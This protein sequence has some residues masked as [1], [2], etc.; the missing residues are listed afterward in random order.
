MV[1]SRF[2]SDSTSEDSNRAEKRN[3]DN[4][5]IEE[6]TDTRASDMQDSKP[7]FDFENL[8]DT[9]FAKGPEETFGSSADRLVHESAIFQKCSYDFVERVLMGAKKALCKGGQRMIEEGAA[10]PCSMFFVLWG[11]AEV[12]CSGE[13]CSL[14]KEGDSI[15]ESQ[16]LG[17]SSKW[18]YS[19]HATSMCMVCEISRAVME[20]ALQ[21]FAEEEAHFQNILEE[22]QARKART[23]LALQG[24][25]SLRRGSEAF[26]SE[27][28]SKMDNRVYFPEQILFAEGAED[29]SL[30][31]LN[32]GIVGME[33]AGRLVRFEEVPTMHP[34][35]AVNEDL[36]LQRQNRRKSSVGLHSGSNTP[37]SHTTDSR[38]SM[39]HTT[40]HR[41]LDELDFRILG[42]ESVLGAIDAR[43]ITARAKSMCHVSILYR[44]SFRQTLSKYPHDKHL[45]QPFLNLK[46]EDTFQRIP[47]REHWPF[48]SGHL[49]D[50]FF[51]FL[52]RHIEKRILGIGDFLVLDE[53]HRNV[54]VLLTD[55]NVSLCQIDRG[56]MLLRSGESES[57]HEDH[58]VE[59]GPGS[60]ICGDKFWTNNT[61]QALDTCCISILHRGVVARALEHLSADRDALLPTLA[62]QQHLKMRTLGPQKDKMAKVLRERSIFADTSEGFLEQ[63]IRIGA[64]RVFMPGDRIIQQ[65]T[66][67]TSIFI[68]SIGTANVVNESVE[69]IN[70]QM[71]R[72]LTDEGTLPHG[73]VFG[74][75]VMLAVESTRTASIIAS[76]VCCTWEVQHSVI[77][78]LLDKYPSERRKFQKLIA[79]H[80]D[81]LAVPGIIYL[82]FFSEFH[83]QFRTMIGVKCERQIYF[84]GE[85]IL[86]E[87]HLGDRMFVLNV[88]TAM[89]SMQHHKVTQATGSFPC[90]RQIPGNQGTVHTKKDTSHFGFNT[91]CG[92]GGHVKYPVT[93]TSET[94]CQ[95]LVISRCTWQHALHT[96]PEMRE[97]SRAME[98]EEKYRQ[99]RRRESFMPMVERRRTFQCVIDAL[100]S[101]RK[102]DKAHFLET[103]F[104]QWVRYTA[105][106]LDFKREEKEQLECNARK[107]E[108]WLTKRKQ[109]LEQVKPLRDLQR[110]V[111]RNLTH[112]GPLKMPRVS[113]SAT[114]RKSPNHSWQESESP[115]M[116]PSPAWRQS[117]LTARQQRRSLPPLPKVRPA[118]TTKPHNSRQAFTREGSVNLESGLLPKEGS[119]STG[120][121]LPASAPAAVATLL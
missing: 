115:Y 40:L 49:S 119:G 30:F 112:R 67:G 38:R 84:P 76:T 105:K 66:H 116:S 83:Q 90:S 78:A 77:L 62:K 3:V 41:E 121:Q 92:I 15:G 42:E 118:N 68:L 117:P 99:H 59:L 89:V 32:H 65:G 5:I 54:H 28:E 61:I 44:A 98:I 95:V 36:G 14:L 48:N 37:A 25:A 17:C 93:V 53:L 23:G 12:S 19:V 63:I 113:Q 69:E 47:F 104:Q 20:D 16:L 21:D 79:R 97:I 35:L 94:M 75:L 39:T 60:V 50:A 91:I 43:T 120:R 11:I 72:T 87:G 33:I 24:C 108:Q 9:G 27:L 109:Q 55:G 31:I 2:R 34:R 46:N 57:S 10:V 107:I 106:V 18:H 29:G 111:D 7:D 85:T 82:P 81:K 80:L 1:G 13:T 100:S 64:I 56:R 4:A 52:G 70:G 103:Y 114:P 86:R 110:L 6:V 96:Y 101:E 88:G 58:Q 74:E 26:L 8:R 45:I 51:E 22:A 102:P 71:W 73:S